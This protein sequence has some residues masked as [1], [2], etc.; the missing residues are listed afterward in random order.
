MR[1]LC[2]QNQEKHQ[3]SFFAEIVEKQ[4]QTDDMVCI[5]QEV[6]TRG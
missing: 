3:I 2:R 1:G 4:K 6:M 5:S